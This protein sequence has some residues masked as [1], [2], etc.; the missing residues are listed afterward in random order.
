M[1]VQRCYT[2]S[3]LQ[4]RAQRLAGFNIPDSR[5]VVSRRGC[6]L[7]AVSTEMRSEDRSIVC[8]RPGEWLA[9]AGIEN[10]KRLCITQRDQ[11]LTV[12][13]EFHVLDAVA[14]PNAWGSGQRKIP[15]KQSGDEPGGGQFIRWIAPKDFGQT[16]K[17]GRGFA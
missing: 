16:S 12:R 14:F 7:L 8:E 2:G 17:R 6:N 11:F 5:G 10:A 9:G 15:M 4:R 13:T 3:V 1:E